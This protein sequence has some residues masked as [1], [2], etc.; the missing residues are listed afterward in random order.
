MKFNTKPNDPLHPLVGGMLKFIRFTNRFKNIKRLIWYKG[1]D[2][3]ERNGEHSYQLAMLAWFMQQR[4]LPHLNREKLLLYA[5]V[6]DKPE[7]YAGD[8]PAFATKSEPYAT[9]LTHKSKKQREQHA[10][11]RI[12]REWKAEFPDMVAYMHAYHRQA[13]EESRFIYA[14]D[15]LLADLNIFEDGGRTNRKLGVTLEEVIAYKQPRAAVHPFVLICFDEFCRYC[16]LRPELFFQ[17]EQTEV[18]E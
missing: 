16:R 11:Q 8:T 18:A 3:Q 4:H 10:M 2:E 14:F 17:P 6:H 7:V 9:T 12:E 15:K 1:N 5:L 13:D